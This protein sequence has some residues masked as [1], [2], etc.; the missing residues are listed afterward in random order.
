MFDRFT[1][2]ARK[3]L[4]LAREESKNF[5]HD[6][7]GTEHILLGLIKEGQGVAAAVLQNLGLSLERIRLEVEKKV[8][9]GS[10]IEIEGE[11]EF[12]PKAKRVI[13]LA[14]DEA[15]KMSHNYI[16]TEHL[17]LGLVLEE[18]G[19][20]ANVLQGLGLSLSKIKKE[21][22]QLLGGGIPSMGS[23]MGG[24]AMDAQEETEKSNTPALDSFGRD[25]TLLAKE[26]KLDPIIGRKVE[27][28]RVLQVLARR[29]KNNPV[30][31]GEAGVGKTAIIEGLAQMI[32]AGTIPEL[33]K[34]KRIV[35][36]DLALMIAGTKYRGQ[37]E[38]R[39]KAVMEEIKKHKEVIL[40]IDELHTLVGAGGAEGAIDASNILKPALSRGEIQIIGATTLDEYR[41]HIEKDS[42]LERRFQTVFVGA[43]NV[44]ETI[45]ILKGLRSRY[46]EHHGA[47]ITD[48]AL[49]AAAEMSDRYISGRFLPDK[50]IDVI[51]E[52][53][54]KVRL[55]I[56]TMPTDIHELE[57]NL[58]DT[59]KE[60]EEAITK[61]DFEA[62]AKLRD[63]ERRL[64]KE[65]DE[66]EKGWK[67]SKADVE[68]VVTVEDVAEVVSKISG[69]PVTRLTEEETQRLV[70]MEAEI[71]SFIIG[72]EQAV[73]VISNAVRRSKAGLKDPN[74]PIGTFMF[75]GPTGVGKTLL[76]KE[77]ARFMFG[78]EEAMIEIDMSEY[79]EKFAVS[80]LIG[81]PPGYVGY[82]EGGQLSEKVRRKPYSVI[83]LDEIEKAH[84]DVFNILLQI[85]EEG[86]LTDNFGRKVDFKNTILILT[87]NVGVDTIRKNSKL[88]FSAVEVEEDISYEGMKEKLQEEVKK[89]FKPEFLNRLDDVIVFKSLTKENLKK[90][91]DIEVSKVKQRLGSAQNKELVLQDS[92][93]KFLI[94]KGFDPVYGAR[95][96]K[97]SIQRY[98]EEPLSE[99]LLK[100]SLQESEV[101]EVSADKD[102]LIFTGKTAKKNKE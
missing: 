11:I 72:Q 62:A 15:R 79:M 38:E 71:D 40:F 19:A 37:F 17:L 22:M 26:D 101:I 14:M 102:K 80:R 5:N 21:I 46:E 6:Y 81:A 86:R 52:A 87:S 24:S 65:M 56:T 60:K 44:E 36:L 4:L 99:E 12:T 49:V 70:D 23:P 88:G 27:V 76:A 55:S 30:L 29:T 20:A 77:L 94:E 47:K 33:L 97:R 28:E 43:P 2:R 51:D 69:V 78:E 41:K 53:G 90:I 10:N 9:S 57:K 85:L 39:I 67:E 75:L 91:V 13:E 96:L 100:G 50:A 68:T 84:P 73:K 32:V 34:G 7:I 48:D 59:V 98:L 42:A 63:T 18:K 64:H 16:G 58:E 54:S 74:R 35:V 93:K 66:K 8:E 61:Q 82:E 3:V 25:L 89:V 92:A 45:E 83:L 95:P 31:L 1:E